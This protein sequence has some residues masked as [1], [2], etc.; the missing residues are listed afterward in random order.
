M[1]EVL[2]VLDLLLLNLKLLLSVHS[3]GSCSLAKFFV[4]L[5]QFG[6]VLVEVVLHKNV[7]LNSA[8]KLVDFAFLRSHNLV[9]LV[10][11]LE[12]LKELQLEEGIVNVLF[13]DSLLLSLPSSDWQVSAVSEAVARLNGSVGIYCWF[14]RPR[15]TGNHQLAHLSIAQICSLVQ[16]EAIGVGIVQFA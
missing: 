14:W 16:F 12:A 1:D 15:V 11:L 5:L 9:L 4:L 7:P 2:E 3:F 13:V 6:V 8:V 10:D